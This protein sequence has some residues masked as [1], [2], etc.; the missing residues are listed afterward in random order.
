MCDHYEETLVDETSI[1]N[2]DGRLAVRH[3][4]KRQIGAPHRDGFN[5]SKSL[6]DPKLSTDCINLEN[7]EEGV[8]SFQHQVRDQHQTKAVSFAPSS[9]EGQRRR[10]EHPRAI[11][12]RSCR[13]SRILPVD[14]I[15][16]QGREEV[17]VSTLSFGQKA[18]TQVATPK[19]VPHYY[20][21]LVIALI[22][23]ASA[24]FLVAFYLS[25]AMN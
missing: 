16:V 6:V 13:Q 8:L 18:Q 23:S 22:V 15:D 3:L 12:P 1:K 7:M 9:D 24:A 10:L 4:E 20:V 14:V 21:C 19:E 25:H 11:A 17:T 2:D 5:G